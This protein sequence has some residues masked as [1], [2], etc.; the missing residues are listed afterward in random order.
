M[1][2][3]LYITFIL[4]IIAWAVCYFVLAIESPLIH[5]LLLASFILGIIWYKIKDT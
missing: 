5:L 3:F 2:N 4:I 1:K